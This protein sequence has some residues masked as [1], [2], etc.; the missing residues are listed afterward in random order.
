MP[1]ITSYSGSFDILRKPAPSIEGGPGGR[2]GRLSLLV[3]LDEMADFL[4]FVAGSVETVDVGTST[5]ERIMPAS[6]PGDPEMLLVAYK[7]EAFGGPNPGGASFLSGS[8]KY[9]QVDCDFQ[10]LPFGTDGET[11]YY[12]WSRETGETIIPVPNLQLTFSNGTKSPGEFGLV[13]PVVNLTLTTYLSTTDV[14]YA[15]DSMV[16]KINSVAVDNFPQYTLRFTGIKEDYARGSFSRTLTK[17]YGFQFRAQH[18]NKHIRL[19]GN[20]DVATLG[21]TGIGAY[22]TADLNQLKWL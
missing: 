5:I 13:V 20:W 7:A 21:S 19:D 8:F 15:V 9:W 14:T 2:S 3:P 17:S 10:T 1:S 12:T 11:A 22:L 6:F 4:S 18:W 16:G